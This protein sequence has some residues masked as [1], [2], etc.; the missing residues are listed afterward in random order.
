[1]FLLCG[2]ADN[3]KRT[4]RTKHSVTKSEGAA[5]HPSH[6]FYVTVWWLL[7][8]KS[9]WRLLQ[10]THIHFCF[11]SKLSLGLNTSTPRHEDVWES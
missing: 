10:N 1:M 8:G 6:L 3:K 2:G 7:M 5:T 4:D 9:G 11:E